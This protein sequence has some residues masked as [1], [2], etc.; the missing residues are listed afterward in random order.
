MVKDAELSDKL[1]EALEAYEAAYE[2]ADALE[3]AQKRC[4]AALKVLSIKEWQ[5]F[6]LLE[7]EL[8]NRREN[9]EG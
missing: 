9:E 8:R 6:K 2:A 1:Q 3:E 4:T 5:R 7:T